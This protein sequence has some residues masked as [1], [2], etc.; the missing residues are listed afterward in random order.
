MISIPPPEEIATWHMVSDADFLET[1]WFTMDRVSPA[2]FAT[3]WQF[4]AGAKLNTGDGSNAFLF[5]ITPAL[6]TVNGVQ[7]ARLT[8]SVP[9]ASLAALFVGTDNVTKK[10]KANLIYKQPGVTVPLLAAKMR[11]SVER[12][13][14]T[15]VP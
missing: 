3:S 5:T 12:G 10:L 14:T 1:L 11:I 15:W 4:Q 8:L 13:T 7:K 9:M 6:V 2:D